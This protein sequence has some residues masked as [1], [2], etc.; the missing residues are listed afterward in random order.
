MGRAAAVARELME[1]QA[2]LP[3]VVT[4][5]MRAQLNPAVAAELHPVGRL[6]L[7]C[8]RGEWEE[9]YTLARFAT[10]PLTLPREPALDPAPPV[11]AAG[12]PQRAAKALPAQDEGNAAANSAADEVAAAD[13]P[14]AWLQP[15]ASGAA[16]T[17][18]E[19]VPQAASD[20]EAEPEPV[21]A[22]ASAQKA[23]K[24][25]DRRLL[26]RLAAERRRQRS[27]AKGASSSDSE[28]RRHHGASA[29]LPT[30]LASAAQLSK[31]EAALLRK[32]TGNNL[33]RNTSR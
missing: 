19:G 25:E 21:G 15:A 4:A 16:A 32:G 20:C 24:G 13:G 33:P 28:V 2:D 27:A 29:K 30:L 3:F 10:L 14:L 18:G 8:F 5:S 7:R 26:Q 11:G 23:G 6:P 1:T 9:C 31:Q 17:A 12:A 22:S